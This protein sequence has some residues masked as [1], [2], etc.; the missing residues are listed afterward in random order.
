[1]LI[2]KFFIAVWKD[3]VSLMSG[4]ASIGLAFWSAFGSFNATWTQQTLVGAAILCFVIAG[5]R[6]WA[7]EHERWQALRDE[8]DKF[9]TGH[10]TV[11]I[12]SVF[13][14]EFVK[15]G[16]WGGLTAITYVLRLNSQGAESTALD[17]RLSML[18]DGQTEPV[19]YMPTHFEGSLSMMDAG[20]PPFV[21]KAADA[22]YTQT[23]TTPIPRGGTVEGY[24]QFRVPYRSDEIQNTHRE[25]IFDDVFGQPHVV[26]V[27]LS[28]GTPDTFPGLRHYAGMKE[29]QFKLTEEG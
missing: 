16:Q 4:A 12:I 19:I 3:W 21:A 10:F 13:V 7:K 24:I 6:I 11:K 18:H 29:S 27:D 5:Y 2:G 25:L 17:W 14:G 1:M 15:D 20:Q 22:I 28:D 9:H 26:T 23:A 8:I